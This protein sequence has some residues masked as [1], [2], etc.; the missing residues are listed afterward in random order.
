[1]VRN[2]DYVEWL[3]R[4]DSKEVIS[5]GDIVAKGAKSLKTYPMQNK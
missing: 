4:L 3:E 1:M 2:G 5:T